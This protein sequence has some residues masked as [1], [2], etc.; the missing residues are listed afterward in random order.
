L[1]VC[2]KKVTSFGSG[3]HPGFGLSRKKKPLRS[4]MKKEKDD[5]K[6]IKKK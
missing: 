2:S 3:S 5:Q 1:S 6:I 4:K